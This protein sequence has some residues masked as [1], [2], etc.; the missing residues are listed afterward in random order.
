MKKAEVC[1]GLIIVSKN[2]ENHGNMRSS[3]LNKNIEHGNKDEN[4]IKCL[5]F[6]S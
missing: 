3:G 5:F 1:K 4:C 6:G 2:C